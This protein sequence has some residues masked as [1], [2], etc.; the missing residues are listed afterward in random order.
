MNRLDPLDFARAVAMLLIFISHSGLPFPFDCLGGIGVIIFFAI[1]GYQ[2]GRGFKSGRYTTSSYLRKRFCAVGLPYIIF[3]LFVALIVDP[4]YSVNNPVDIIR[5]ITFIGIWE[6]GPYLWHLWFIPVLMQLYLL[7]LVFAYFMRN[8]KDDVRCC[9]WL[10]GL[11]MSGGLAILPLGFIIGFDTYHYFWGWIFAFF[12]AYMIS[13]MGLERYTKKIDGIR[14]NNVPLSINA[15]KQNKWRIFEAF[16][17][18]SFGFYLWHLPALQSVK[19]MG[20]ENSIVLILVSLTISC[21]LG[22]IWY[23]TVEKW[24]KGLKGVG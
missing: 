16:S 15:V 10:F 4:V 23:L 19:M 7:A 8:I 14:K 5:L 6:T 20:V 3:V 21:M 11:I 17:L 2:I 24:A 1:S 12:G 22:A 13:Y 9:R 18:I